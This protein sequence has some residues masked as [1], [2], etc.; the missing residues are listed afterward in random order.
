MRL[1]LREG[2]K[3]EEIKAMHRLY[4]PAGYFD[5]PYHHVEYSRILLQRLIAG[6]KEVLRKSCTSGVVVREKGKWFELLVG[7]KSHM[8]RPG[9][10]LFFECVG[11]AAVLLSAN[12]GFSHEAVK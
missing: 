3:A 6:R 9:A 11:G 12:P 4:A 2:E 7:W 10:K 5:D 1:L 8:N